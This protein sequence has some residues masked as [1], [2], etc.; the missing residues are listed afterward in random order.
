MATLKHGYSEL[1]SPGTAFSSQRGTLF[2][3]GHAPGRGTGLVSVVAEASQSEA[4]QLVYPRQAVTSWFASG[5]VLRVSVLEV[6]V[7]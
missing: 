5:V 6:E 4:N 3:L 2:C 7:H 1:S